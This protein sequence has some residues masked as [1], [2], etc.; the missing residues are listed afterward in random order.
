MIGSAL[1]APD[2]GKH[3]GACAQDAEIETSA[4]QSSPLAI[5]FGWPFA[6][7]AVG[8]DGVDTKQFR[9][10]RRIAPA[11]AAFGRDREFRDVTLGGFQAPRRAVNAVGMVDQ[12]EAQF[13]FGP[14]A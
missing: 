11:E 2:T 12:A 14:Q 10:C 9:N 6:S 13:G 1:R 7:G 3:D 4:S 5:L 8:N